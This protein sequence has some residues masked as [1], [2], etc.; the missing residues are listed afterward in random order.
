MRRFFAVSPLIVAVSLVSVSAVSAQS[1]IRLGETVDGRLTPDHPVE[2]DGAH[3]ED[4]LLEVPEAQRVT[5]DLR[6][7]QFDTFLRLFRSHPDGMDP[8]ATDDDGAGNLDSRLRL[9]LDE[10]GTYVVRATSYGEGATGAFTLSVRAAPE[11]I[12]EP[13]RPISDGETLR[14]ELEATDPLHD[15]RHYDEFT[16]EAERGQRVRVSVQADHDSFLYLGRETGEDFQQLAT[17][18][19]G[20]EGLDAAMTWTAPS[21]GIYTIRPSSF[22]QEV[23]GSYEVLLERMPE[24]VTADPEAYPGGRVAGVLELTDAQGMVRGFGMEESFYDDWTVRGRAGERLVISVNSTAFDSF[25]QFGRGTGDD[26]EELKSDDDGGANYNSLL[27]IVLPFDG[28][29]T[30]RVSPVGDF[31]EGTYELEVESDR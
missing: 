21:D 9:G 16:F 8:V 5:I 13:P 10:A 4:Y 11:V 6:S 18:D 15:G 17:D 27:A 1:S 2:S 19:D 20:G 14:G 3:Y 26:F 25:L 28:T 23:E 29:Y 12:V 30:V 7:E 24:P 31:G 22:G